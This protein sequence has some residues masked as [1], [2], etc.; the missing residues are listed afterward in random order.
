[1]IITEQTK[2]TF[3]IVMKVIYCW[4]FKKYIKVIIIK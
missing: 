3:K 4:I 2:P 1:M